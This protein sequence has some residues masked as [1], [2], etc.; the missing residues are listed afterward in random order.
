M[1]SMRRAGLTAAAA[2]LAVALTATSAFAATKHGTDRGEVLRGTDYADTI[3][4]Y[5]GADLVYGYGGKDVLH[6]GTEA[7]W[8]DKILGGDQADL[9]Y[10]Q[11]GEDGLYG[12]R[13]DDRIYGGYGDD[14]VQ[15]DSGEDTLD[16]GPGAD[17]INAQDGQRD[18]IVIRSG[19]YDVVYY[20]R[21]LDVLQSQVYPQGT[22][23][24]G[25]GVTV[26][27]AIEAGKVELA[28]EEP[29]EGLFEHTGKVLVEH[30]GEELL[31]AEKGLKGHLEHGDEILDPMGRSA[32]AEERGR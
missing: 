32:G 6:G 20:D 3:Y 21:G 26:D 12:G 30:E 16:G 18:T 7:G 11:S 4:A 19:E 17:E 1:R 24:E 15:G 8:G 22:A 29:P 10:G 23:G 5:G 31:V 13:G 14:L 2:M 9:I 25:T 27:E 28:A